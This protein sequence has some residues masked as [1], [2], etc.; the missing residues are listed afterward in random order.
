MSGEVNGTVCIITNGSG[1]IIGQGSGTLALAGTPI[2]TSN[3]SNGDNV[4]MIDGQL[5]GQQLTYAC[6]FV[7]STSTQ[8]QKVNND[9][10]TGINDTYT[11]TIPT[12]GTTDESYTALM[13]PGGISIAMPFGETVTSS[14]TFSSNGAIT[15]VPYVS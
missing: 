10:I 5:A 7:Y 11:I 6:V 1:E 9:A 12:V 4:T 13:Q 14:I 2:I 15:H 3:K 8:F